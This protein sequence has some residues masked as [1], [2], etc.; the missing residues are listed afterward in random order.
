MIK[1]VS[2]EGFH[3]RRGHDALFLVTELEDALILAAWRATRIS[4]ICVQLETSYDE[5]Y[6]FKV[7]KFGN[8]RSKNWATWTM[9][10]SF[11]V[12]KLEAM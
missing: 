11:S 5:P 10:G 7:D 9:S 4:W 3:A 6:A 8:M 2:T 12:P 1:R